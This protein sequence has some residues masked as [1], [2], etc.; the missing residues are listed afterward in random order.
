MV[1]EVLARHKFLQGW[2]CSLTSCEVLCAKLLDTHFYFM[3]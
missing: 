2:T 3:W 1:D